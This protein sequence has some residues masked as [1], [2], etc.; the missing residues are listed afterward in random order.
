MRSRQ[1]RHIQLGHVTRSESSFTA[2][3]PEISSGSSGLRR[4][5]FLAERHC[6]QSNSHLHHL[7]STH[8]P[9]HSIKS[10]ISPSL[11]H[12]SL[13][14]TSQHTEAT[15]QHEDV[16]TSVG[17][18]CGH[19]GS[20]RLLPAR[21]RSS[22]SRTLAVSAAAGRAA[23]RTISTWAREEKRRWRFTWWR[24]WR[25]IVEWRRQVPSRDQVSIRIPC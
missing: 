12:T 8:R 11:S 19:F 16:R 25:N 21:D 13:H 23:A 17:P 3:D 4:W 6:T 2:T 20:A 15:A 9:T 10:T 22:A 7:R 24:W 1:L 14:S 5:G 18:P